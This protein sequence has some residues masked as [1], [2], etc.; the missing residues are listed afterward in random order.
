MTT[1]HDLLEYALAQK[2]SD[3]MIKAGSPPILRVD[4]RVVLTEL[5]SMSAADCL[6]TVRSIQMAAG[7]DQLLNLEG[8]PTKLEPAPEISFLQPDERDYVFTIP[9]LVRVRANVFLQ[10]GTLAAALRI[11]S[12][13]PHSLD[14]LGLPPI[15]KDLALQRGGLILVTGATGSGKSTTLAALVDHIN[16]HRRCNVITIEDPIEY[17]FHDD[18]SVI[19]Q[20]EVRK[21]SP[22]F[23]S[24]LHA[25]LR[26][27][28]DVIMVGEMR[29][30]ET[31]EAT[32]MAA[33]MGHLV[34]STLHTISAP[35]TVDRI[36]NAFP[37]QRQA[38]ILA[39]LTT[40][41]RGIVA[42]RLVQKKDG[43]RVAAVE[44]MTASPSVLKLIEDGQMG[45]LAATIREGGHYGMVSMNQSLERLVRDDTITLDEAMA[46][47][48]NPTEL[49]QLLRQGA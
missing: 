22:S 5:P 45:N 41:L 8:Q 1:V 36:L 25:V 26:Q 13:K 35:A 6:E 27:T 40:T 38:Q 24:A 4:G 29:R 10:Q 3:L 44:V 39:Q 43:G 32:L 7:R 17:V 30:Q 47:S 37:A 23:M 18:Q 21:D 15:L 16:H 20:R 11:V 33:E 12:L 42:Q 46:S 28:P 48:P 14:E 31:M 9:N 34:L 2:A 19:Y 49:R